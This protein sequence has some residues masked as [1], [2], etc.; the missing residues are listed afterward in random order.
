MA[1]E[2]KGA[3][4]I[5]DSKARIE[6]VEDRKENIK[7]E[8]AN[9]ADTKEQMASALM[10][11]AEKKAQDADRAMEAASKTGDERALK[12]AEKEYSEAN[13]FADE[14][15]SSAKSTGNTQLEASARGEALRICDMQIRSEKELEANTKK[16]DEA[17]QSEAEHQQAVLD[18]IEASVRAYEKASKI[19]DPKTGN[20][21][22]KD[23]QDDLAKQR[24]KAMADIEANR[25]NSTDEMNAKKLGMTD[26]FN[27]AVRAQD[28][29]L[30]GMDQPDFAD[31]V[32]GWFIKNKPKVH[33]D[34]EETLAD[35]KQKFEDASQHWQVKVPGLKELAQ[36]AGSE[37]AKNP[38]ERSKQMEGVSAK[39]DDLQKKKDVVPLNDAVQDNL[40]GDIQA[41]IRDSNH[42]AGSSF[43]NISADFTAA[44]KSVIDDLNAITAAT[45]ISDEQMTKLRTDYLAMGE[46]AGVNQKMPVYQRGGLQD[47]ESLGNAAL[48]AKALMDRQRDT[49]ASPANRDALD[50]QQQQLKAALDLRPATDQANQ[51]M[52]TLAGQA[53]RVKAALDAAN[54]DLTGL[55]NRALEQ[56]AGLPTPTT[57]GADTSN[58]QAHAAG[59]L[60]YADSG[61]Y[62]A[63]GRDTIAAM[64][65][66]GEMVMNQRAAM[67]FGPQLQSMN[68][69]CNPNYHSHGGSV[70]N[71]G[72]VTVNFSHG[73][74]VSQSTG[75]DVAQAIKRELRRGS[76]S[77]N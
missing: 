43:A 2:E 58:V 54:Q 47:T 13:K 22:P 44:K 8:G 59:G 61:A 1:E 38:S 7:F 77:M 75:R 76:T 72:D 26:Q 4:A 62:A 73:G 74:T 29:Q 15:M 21:L 41:S 33:F 14:A 40:R 18:K 31:P 57:S 69:G 34:Y 17:V 46:A 50:V 66:P 11:R 19:T 42:L 48:N 65:S 67:T 30:K 49:S 28:A 45:K 6:S 10:A 52:T 53:E 51:G 3:K 16:R 55:H 71:V 32:S 39:I 60:L 9:A 56:A 24:A 37:V 35:A 25:F 70:T 64:L 27:K 36:A 63:R 20:L 12:R 68:A 23:M 5:L